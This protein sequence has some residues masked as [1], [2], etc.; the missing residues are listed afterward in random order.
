MD[1]RLMIG[2]RQPVHGLAWMITVLAMG[3]ATGDPGLW[4]RYTETDFPAPL[5]SVTTRLGNVLDRER[6]LTYSPWTVTFGKG[7]PYAFYNCQQNKHCEIT[8]K[9]LKCDHSSGGRASYELKLYDNAM[10]ELLI[11]DQ[12]ETLHI[13]CPSDVSL[14]PKLFPSRGR[15]KS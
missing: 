9:N 14:E 12:Q 15:A 4:Q 11:P 10:C 8:I 7:I 1:V 6:D 3:C 13:V 5:H 2:L